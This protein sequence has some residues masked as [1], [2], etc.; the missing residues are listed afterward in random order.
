MRAASFDIAGAELVIKIAALVDT[1][2]LPAVGS[3]HFRP[4]PLAPSRS[5]RT[6]TS[7]V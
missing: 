4:D 3:G 1:V 2:A 5:D 6:V 7:P